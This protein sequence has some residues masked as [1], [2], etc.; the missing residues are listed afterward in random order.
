MLPLLPF[1]RIARK[2]GVK[3]ISKDAIEELR[4]ASLEYALELAEKAVKVSQH[5]GKRTVQEE[6]VKFVLKE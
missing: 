3:R 2:A 1:E 5:A 6:D 4:D